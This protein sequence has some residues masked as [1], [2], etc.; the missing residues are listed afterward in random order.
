MLLI[1]HL[2]KLSVSKV[3]HIF[4]SFERSQELCEGCFCKL[5]FCKFILNCINNHKDYL[6]VSVNMPL[7]QSRKYI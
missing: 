7:I 6:T 3:T 4:S 2:N 1:E 5:L